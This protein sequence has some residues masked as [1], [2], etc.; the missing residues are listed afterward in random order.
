MNNRIVVSYKKGLTEKKVR[1]KTMAPAYDTFFLPAAHNEA[2]DILQR[3]VFR[4]ATI[5]QLFDFRS[6]QM[7]QSC[8]ARSKIRE[9]RAHGIINTDAY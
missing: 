2:V 9:I 4:G 7:D 1:G 3:S 6:L 8:R 5:S